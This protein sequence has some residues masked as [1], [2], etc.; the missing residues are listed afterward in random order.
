MEKL[1]DPSYLIQEASAFKRHQVVLQ[2]DGP[3]SKPSV[4][5]L[6]RDYNSDHNLITNSL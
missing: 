4:C 2:N 1:V 5:E 3:C 6:S